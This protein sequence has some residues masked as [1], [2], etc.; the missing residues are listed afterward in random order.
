MADMQINYIDDM[1]HIE[2]TDDYMF[3][4]VM[5]HSHICRNVIECLLPG[6]SVADVK[7]RDGAEIVPETQKTLQGNIG[8]HSVRL[9]VYLDD[10]KTV[11]N[12]EMQTGNKMNLPKR[13]RYYGGR[14]DCD[15]LEKNEDY[16]QLRPTYV[17]FI[18]TFD[19]FN[20]DQYHYS[21]E[22]RCAEVE[23]L[24]LGDESYKLFFNAKGHKGEISSELKSLLDYM[25]DP[26]NM[27]ESAKTP[28][29]KEIDGVVEFANHDAEWR[30]GYMTV[31]QMQL[32]AENRGENLFAS[33]MKL[34]LSAKRYEDAEKATTDEV[35]RNE[36]YK[37]FGL[38]RA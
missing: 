35:R 18:C 36:L 25:L 27:P 24:R 23:G 12:V 3:G 34:L 13:V 9:D 29:V 37:E 33:L 32:D 20:Q 26:K 16:N 21:F 14:I 28:L 31:R 30:R 22:N 15:Q 11:Y 2:I 17:I 6:V 38:S 19:P 8:T 4:Y 5:R 7:Y 1:E 10:G